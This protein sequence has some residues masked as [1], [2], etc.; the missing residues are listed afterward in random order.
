MSIRVANLKWVVLFVVLI[1]AVAVPSIVGA[2]GARW[3]GADPQVT[4]GERTVN[5]WIEWPSEYTCT[6]KGR[7][8][9]KFEAAGGVLDAESRDSFECDD[10]DTNT[11]R[12]KSKIVKGGQNGVF[13]V[14]RARLNA[15]EN[16][17]VTLDVYVD[18]KLVQVCRGRSNKKFNCD[19]I[20]LK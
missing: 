13:R 20:R 10:G 11:V 3:S 14:A 7:V 19:P 1:L 2:H 6:I 4:I 8:K 9:F 18:D 16:F 12:T 17:P 15:T 5:V